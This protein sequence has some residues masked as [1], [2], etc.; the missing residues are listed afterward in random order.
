MVD[1]CTD[2]GESRNVGRKTSLFCL[3][4][5]LLRD[6]GSRVEESTGGSGEKNLIMEKERSR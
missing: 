2:F 5:T 4:K 6:T 1:I 3:G